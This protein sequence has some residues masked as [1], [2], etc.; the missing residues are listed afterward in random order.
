MQKNHWKRKDFIRS[1]SALGLLS[2]L[3]PTT[4]AQPSALTVQQVI[5][6][7]IKTVPGAPFKDTVDT[8]KSGD[9]DQLVTGIVTTMFATAETIEKAAAL[10]ANFIIAHE[11]TFYNHKD[12]TNWL[13]KDEVY[14]Y[15]SALLNKYKIAVWRFH[16]YMHTHR[17]DGVYMGLLD[18]LDW[19]K[20]A[21]AQKPA[22][23][24]LASTTLV[25]VISHVKTKLGIA[26]LRFI[27]EKNQKIEK[28]LLIPGAAGG[29]YQISLAAA[30]KPDLLIVGE[31]SEWETMEYVRDLR[32]S[33]S[34]T[35]LIILGH[36][37]SEQAGMEWLVNWLAPKVNG[38]KVTYIPNTIPFDWE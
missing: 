21:D 20:M 12:E 19:Q 3:P 6:L 15:K 14:Q 24:K 5:D 8:I 26:H 11:P 32:S 33:G 2:A 36:I 4:Y 13:E 18:K 25:D 23:I 27:G 28:V 35:A 34:K 38:I 22:N 9:K 29:K 16:D 1:I 7:I 37:S 17:P 31:L 10:N 30:E